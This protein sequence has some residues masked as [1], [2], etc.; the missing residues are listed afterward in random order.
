[1]VSKE[2]QGFKKVVLVE[3]PRQGLYTVAFVT[4]ATSGELRTKTGGNC[5]NLFIP[6]TPNPTSGYYV[7]V[8]EE[9]VTPLEMSVEDAFK[10]IISGGIITP[11]ENKELRMDEN[12]VKRT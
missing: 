8:P 10:L 3:F 12:S 6:T 1:M 2:G 11:A 4:G 9:S 7:M 5:I